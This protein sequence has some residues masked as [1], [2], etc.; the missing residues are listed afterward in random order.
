MSP[1]RHIGRLLVAL[2]LLCSAGGQIH[3]FSTASPAPVLA[4]KDGD[5]FQGQQK[6]ALPF[7]LFS[8]RPSKQTPVTQQRHTRLLISKAW[9]PV[10][11]FTFIKR[12]RLV[13]TATDYASPHILQRTPVVFSLRG[14]PSF[15]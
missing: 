15:A 11:N 7:Q 4:A 2:L 5:N 6:Q 13:I 10:A 12:Y 9:Q 8:A 1:Y 3:A 14:P